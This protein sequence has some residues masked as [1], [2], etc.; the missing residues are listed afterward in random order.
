MRT[1]KLRIAVGTEMTPLLP[2]PRRHSLPPPPMI[3]M[4]GEHA[5]ALMSTGIKLGVSKTTSASG[6]PT[7]SNVN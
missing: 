2:P 7:V 1:L 6:I 3:Q 5:G 4:I